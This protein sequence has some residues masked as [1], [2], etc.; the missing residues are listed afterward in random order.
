MDP[1]ELQSHLEFYRAHSYVI[2]PDLLSPE[3]VAELNAAM[4]RDRAQRPYF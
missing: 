3:Q 1:A 4:D 2:L